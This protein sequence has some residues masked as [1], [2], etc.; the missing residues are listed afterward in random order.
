MRHSLFILLSTLRT[1]HALAQ[2]MPQP[3]HHWPLD[4]TTDTLAADISG[5]EHGT[6]QGGAAW[7]SAGRFGGAVQFNGA[8]GRVVAGPCDLTTGPGGIS[9]SLWMK[10]GL[11]A[12]SEQVLLAKSDG[13]GTS[14]IIWSL[15]QVNSTAIRF[16]VR[17]GGNLTELTTPGSSL[18]SGSWYHVCGTYNGSEM[19]IY[20]NGALMAFTSASGTVPYAPSAP[21]CMGAR[22]DGA[23][24]FMGALDD[25]RIYDH[26]LTEMDVIGLVLGNVSVGSERPVDMHVDQAGALVLPPG[27]WSHVIVTDVQG[28]MVHDGHM[29]STRSTLHLP[30]Q[31]PGLY[32]VVLTG[33]T[34]RTCGRVMRL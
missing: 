17:A 22:A 8:D 10:A 27:D 5:G 9:L 19:R 6:L 4:E 2:S 14:G 29:Q 15:S 20:L 12:G 21:A 24:W 32:V 23:A 34:Q 11:M 3:V 33:P 7:N 16:R 28:R 25:V 31:M 1:F 13:P 18:F 26:G 30:W